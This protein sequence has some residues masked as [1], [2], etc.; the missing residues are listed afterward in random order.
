MGLTFL[1]HIAR[2]KVLTFVLDISLGVE[3]AVDAFIGLEKELNTYDK[4]LNLK[5]KCVV[6]N[7][8]DVLPTSQ[9]ASLVHDFKT[10]YTSNAMRVSLD[11]DAVPFVMT[12]C[13]RS[14]GKEELVGVVCSLFF[15]DIEN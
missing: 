3:A 7:K 1:K 14:E 8:I 15:S 10:A 6:L 13:L 5:K 9:H 2:C 4:S 12:C 11:L